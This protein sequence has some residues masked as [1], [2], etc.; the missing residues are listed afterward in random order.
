MR[1]E[2]SAK[3][4]IWRAIYP[5]EILKSKLKYLLMQ[6][7]RVMYKIVLFLLLGVTNARIVDDGLWDGK[8]WYD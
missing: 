7:T 8:D 3:I 5:Y 1:F 4:N 6:Q 2:K